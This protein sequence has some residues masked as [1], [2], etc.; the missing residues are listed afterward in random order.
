[1]NKQI[2]VIT[3]A[4]KWLEIFEHRKLIPVDLSHTLIRIMSISISQTSCGMLIKAIILLLFARNSCSQYAS[5]P[6]I[7]VVMGVSIIFFRIFDIGFNFRYTQMRDDLQF[8][9]Y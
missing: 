3:T 8:I 5:T 4:R 2:N 1:M 7:V 6:H 9:I